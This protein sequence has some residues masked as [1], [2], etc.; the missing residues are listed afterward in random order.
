MDRKKLFTG[1]SIVSLC[2]AIGVV[3]ALV[4][5]CRTILGKYSHNMTK[6]L[7]SFCYS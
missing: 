1:V 6:F 4:C 5:P 2:T 7:H 3:G